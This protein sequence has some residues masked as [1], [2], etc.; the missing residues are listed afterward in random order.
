[1]SV[2]NAQL[3]KY[4]D[5]KDVEGVKSTLTG[6]AYVGDSDSFNEFKSSVEYAIKNIDNLFDLDDGKELSIGYSLAEYKKVA[7]LMMNNFSKKK[8][9]AV[10]QIGLKV[11]EKDK[12]TR[13]PEGEVKADNPLS[14]ALKNP[15]KVMIVVLLIV[16]VIVLIM[17]MI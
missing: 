12:D 8:Y 1:M 13:V 14:E 15:V 4:V 2:I 6:L 5:E 3:K 7:R 9:D 11:F 16:A 10:I 17:K